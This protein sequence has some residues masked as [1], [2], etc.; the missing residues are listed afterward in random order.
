ME[1]M[2]LKV[3]KNLVME[4]KITQMD[5][6]QHWCKNHK[7]L[8]FENLLGKQT[9]LED[10]KVKVILKIRR[11]HHLTVVNSKLLT[12]SIETEIQKTFLQTGRDCLRSLLKNL[13]VLTRKNRKSKL[14]KADKRN[15][16]QKLIGNRKRRNQT[17]AMIVQTLNRKNQRISSPKFN[18]RKRK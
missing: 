10:I 7:S 16:K 13:K 4:V 14:R 17:S 11:I 8:W 3:P 6:I 15:Q 2:I 18:K 5:L 12:K 1:M 9:N